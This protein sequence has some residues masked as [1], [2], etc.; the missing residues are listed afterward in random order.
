MFA[1]QGIAEH[2]LPEHVVQLYLEGKESR[3]TARMQRIIKQEIEIK[4]TQAMET[5]SKQIEGPHTKMIKHA[6]K[7]TPAERRRDALHE[8]LDNFEPPSDDSDSDLSQDEATTT[9]RKRKL[10]KVQEVQEAHKKMCVAATDTMG[11]V[12]DLLA[13]V[14]K[15]LDKKYTS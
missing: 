11:K 12:N 9:K 3:I 14:D 15:I 5:Q 6:Q 13:K 7:K 2:N 1:K 10:D 8:K 4:Q